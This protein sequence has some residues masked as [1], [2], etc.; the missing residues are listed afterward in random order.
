MAIKIAKPITTLIFIFLAIIRSCQTLF[1]A[2]V[3][4]LLINFAI[5]KSSGLLNI[6]LLSTFGLFFFLLFDLLYEKVYSK[7]ILEI[8]MKIKSRAALCLIFNPVVAKEVDC[9]ILI[10]GTGLGISLAA[11][12][13][14]GVRAAVCSEPYTAKMSRLH[15]DC[16]IL[17]FG[18]R[19]VGAELAKMIVET[20]L[21]TDFEGGRHQRR[22][23][24]IMDI[25]EKNE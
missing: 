9:G 22:V 25:E 19:V 24:L 23:D 5:S 10:C 13:V 12:K 14:K 18:A 20:W 17:A 16:N 11:N 7:L 2:W 3:V 1:I 21:D 15:N 6:V 8:N 4:K